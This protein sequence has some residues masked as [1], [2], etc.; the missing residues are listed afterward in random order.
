MI[1]ITKENFHPGQI[2]ASGQCFR[3]D[4]AGERRYALTASAYYLEI[5]ELG[6]GSFLFSCTEEEFEKFWRGYFDMDGDYGACIRAIDP[7]DVYLMDAARFGS[8]IRILRQDLWEMIVSFI[9]SQQNNIRRIKKIL[10]LLSQRYGTKMTVLQEKEYYAFPRPEE[11][12]RADE[13]ALRACNLGYR[14]R[15]I[16]STVNS[17][18]SG[19]AD[20]EKIKGMCYQEAREELMKLSGVGEKVA[21]CICL[22]ALHHLEA[23]PVDTH[24][25]KVLKKNYP[26]GFPFEKYKGSEGILQ[27]YIFYYDLQHPEI[28]DR[29]Q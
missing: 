23:F 7:G 25:K 12:A 8:G 6:D 9:V 27:Q 1:K 14:S 4:P 29:K 10:E 21:D 17:V 15:Y 11:L 26:Q 16:K 5:E 18:L 22:F 28:R 19:E 24:I 20:L 3:M 2:C 13:E